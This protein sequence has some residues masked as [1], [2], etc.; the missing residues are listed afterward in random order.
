MT[1]KNKSLTSEMRVGS[2]AQVMLLWYL[3]VMLVRVNPL[4]HNSDF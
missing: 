2:K 4:S 1:D 3:R